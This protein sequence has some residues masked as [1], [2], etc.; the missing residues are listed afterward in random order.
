MLRSS[1]SLP[2]K[3]QHFSERDRN[4]TGLNLE[5]ICKL[6]KSP[7]QIFAEKSTFAKTTLLKKFL[8]FLLISVCCSAQ[9]VLPEEKAA[10]I[11]LYN[12]AGGEGWAIP[13]DTDAEPDE[14]Y[15][16]TTEDGHV[17]E[18][19]L[20]SNNLKGRL[21]SLAALTKLRTLYLNANNLGGDLP[22]LPPTLRALDIRENAFTGDISLV[23]GSLTNLTEL[24]L[25]GN[26][27]SAS[28]FSFL[29]NSPLMASL[30]LSG[31]GLK[32]IPEPLGRLSSLEILNLSGNEIRDFSA[33]AK[34]SSLKELDL[35]GNQLAKV[36][37]EASALKSLEILNLSQNKITDFSALRSLSGL[38]WLSFAENELKAAPVELGVLKD[39]AHLD[40]SGNRLENFQIL[41]RLKNLQLLNLDRNEL[42]A[43]P[44]EVAELPRLQYLSLIGNQ[45]S[46]EIPQNL[47]DIVQL[48]NN[49]Y[50]LNEIKNFHSARRS[51][52]DI[53]Y[54]PQRYDETE[55]VAAREGGEA[56]LKQSL[57]TDVYKISWLKNLDEYT[58]V[59][60]KNF[61]L[62]S[63]KKTDFAD[64]TAEAYYLE[65]SGGGYF[66][67]SLFREPVTL[68][69]GAL[70]TE[71]ADA[72]FAV[73]PN[74]ASDYLHI[75]CG[76]EKLE[77]A[78]IFDQSGR[79]IIKTDSITV[80][81]AALPAGVYTI[82]IKTEGTVRSFKFIK[83]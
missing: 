24:N 48:Q 50:S 26:A 19:K 57:P 39:L 28:S 14:W 83:K 3:E 53:A 76:G 52:T 4:K 61:Q 43:I 69:D 20:N 82:L 11:R 6:K 15:G 9:S 16:I 41:G 55:T 47:P 49:R 1:P 68:A 79:A 22:Q 7:L 25:G 66:E 38:Q 62:G 71:E 35:S 29:Q 12:D 40:M 21:P 31:F 73:Y 34:L 70:G 65:T 81:V 36:P 2:F 63:I 18:I 72:S 13:W 45:L 27:L 60:T 17:T 74:P 44:T 58:G 80:S 30:D 46:G 33:L 59:S 64:Y 8:L 77:S 75:R 32:E 10:L 67:L 23:A 37:N 54:S 78:V 5:D 51:F 56:T 42:S